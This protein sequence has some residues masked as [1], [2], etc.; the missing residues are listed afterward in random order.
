MSS[1]KRLDRYL[2]TWAQG[3]AEREV[4]GGLIQAICGAGIQLAKTIARFD[5][6]ER[7]SA[8]GQR[9]DADN[10]ANSLLLTAQEI[11]ESAI[12]PLPVSVMASAQRDDLLRIDPAARYAIAIDPID[13]SSNIDT[14]LSIGSLFSILESDGDDLCK[15]APGSRLK[16][17]GFLFYGPQTHLVLSCADGCYHFLLD[18]VSEQFYGIGDR[19]QIP[20]GRR[21]FAINTSN[22]RFWDS[23]VRHFIDDC[24]A[25]ADGALGEDF[26]MRWNASLVAEAFR[27]LMRGGVFLYPGDARPGC[28]DGRLRLLFEA[29]P[30]AMLIEQA[31]GS[32][33]NGSL[34]VMEI[35]LASL[36]ARVPL[37]FGCRERVMEVIDYISGNALDS[38]RFPLFANRSLFRS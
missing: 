1:A 17:S 5:L 9:Y 10:R 28:Q 15:V 12:R 20:A 16:A 2:A 23:S 11:F 33:S 37:I 24:I 30:L 34:P 21:E 7:G 22:Y 25:G 13:G 18:P 19:L 31:G 6:V 27:I 26:N 8:V 29:L 38:G 4:I 14:N 3:D 32:A 35:E 36:Q